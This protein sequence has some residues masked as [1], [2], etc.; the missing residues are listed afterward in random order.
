VTIRNGIDLEQFRRDAVHAQTWR[1]RW[2]ISNEAL[3]FGAI[4]RFAPLKGYGTAIEAFQKVQMQFPEKDMKLVL[5]GEGPDEQVLRA[6]AE[7][8]KP[9]GSVV[10]SPFCERPWEP[11]SAFD[12]FVMPSVNEGLPLAL[13]EAMACECCP[14]ATAVGGIP[15]A[16]TGPDLGWLVPPGDGDAFA[17]AMIAAASQTAQQRALIGRSARQHVL[18]NFNAAVQFDALVDFIES[19]P[20]T[21]WVGRRGEHPSL[22]RS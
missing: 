1:Q 19:L 12:L 5:V 2:N 14:V 22:M 6:H 16:V 7:R 9:R 15:E 8:I 20:G 11:L 13:A 10:F 3:I 4:G 17:N 18:E 21:P